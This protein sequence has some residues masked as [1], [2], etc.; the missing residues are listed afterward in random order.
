MGFLEEAYEK[1][2]RAAARP[3]QRLREKSE[4]CCKEDDGY[5]S[6]AMV[7]VGSKNFVGVGCH[8]LPPC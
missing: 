2:E 4:M 5:V 6:L 7:M 8:A 1:M 3:L